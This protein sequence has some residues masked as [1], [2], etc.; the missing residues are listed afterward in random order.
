MTH[1]SKPGGITTA[2]RTNVEDSTRILGKQ[3]TQPVVDSHG[4]QS[5]ISRSDLSGIGVVPDDR[6]YHFRIMSNVDK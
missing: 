3:V 6:V 2:S 5:L 4:S 1:G